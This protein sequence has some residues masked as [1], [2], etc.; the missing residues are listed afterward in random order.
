MSA[1]KLHLDWIKKWGAKW[2]KRKGNKV[3]RQ[4]WLSSE[5]VTS[6]TLCQELKKKENSMLPFALIGLGK[7]HQ[8]EETKVAVYRIH[9]SQSI[10]IHANISKKVKASMTIHH[11]PSRKHMT[12]IRLSWAVLSQVDEIR[13]PL[14]RVDVVLPVPPVIHLLGSS[15]QR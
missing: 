9:S 14:N 8:E 1:V 11:I 12:Y 10:Y 3:H 4:S 2:I 15:S 5:L 13:L 7:K 6:Q